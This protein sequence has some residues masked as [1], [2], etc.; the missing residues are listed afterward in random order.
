MKSLKWP[1]LGL[2]LLNVAVSLVFFLS[3]EGAYRDSIELGYAGMARFFAAHPSPFGWAPL[4]YSG[5]PSHLWYL[6]VI[7]YTGAA[8]MLLMP[9]TEPY[10]AYRLWVVTL[11]CL[12]PVTLFYFVY[13]FTGQRRWAGFT[14]ILFTLVS[15]SYAIF[16]ALNLDRGYNT[17][18][19]RLQLLVKY[20]EGP[21]N[22]GVMLAPLAL[23]ALWR[24]GQEWGFRRVFLA[25]A[26][27]AAVCLTN[28]VAA[29]SL[30]WCCLAMLAAWG[31]V[32]GERRTFAMRLLGTAGLAYLLASFWLTPRYV[33]TTVFNWPVDAIDF[34]PVSTQS[35]VT[36]LV[37]LAGTLMWMLRRRDGYLRFLALSFL[38]FLYV[39]GAHYWFG[40]DVI[41]EG[42]RYVLE[43]EWFGMVLAVELLRRLANSGR[44]WKR[45]LALLGCGAAAGLGAWQAGGFLALTWQKLHPFD[46]ENAPEW[47]VARKLNE[48]KPEG[49]VAVSGGT[50]FR[51]NAWFDVPQLGGTF[52]T[53]LR[54][55]TPVWALYQLRS[56]MDSPRERRVQDAEMLMK[57]A[58]VE[59]VA[60]HGPGSR[61]YYRDIKDAALFDARWEAVFREGEDVIY[62]VPFRGLSHLVRSEELPAERPI[63]P[64]VPL[65]E[66]YVRGLED[67]G[68]PRLSTQWR[69]PSEI[70]IRGEVPEKMLVSVLVSYDGGWR[71]EQDGR[72]LV[73]DR[74]AN[75]HIL[76]RPAAAAQ[77]AIRLRYRPTKEHVAM[78]GVSGLTWA[79]CL[80]LLWRRRGGA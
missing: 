4:Q 75:D 73:V 17:I 70:E 12:A 58:G 37:V 54:N 19:W 25:A 28:W 71:A 35:I 20:G 57:M 39:S 8:A 30:A 74:D 15:F 38:G 47:R 26:L 60:I 64:R 44:P 40:I 32:Q 34:K 46:R 66:A 59:Y 50:R 52:E 51:L 41:P 77:T 78:T 27:L 3:G 1:L 22:A 31:G 42:R 14:A 63:G 36:V 62:R 45:D 5:L 33:V 69:G 53:G 49:R 48:L 13:R 29:F 23:V 10:H 11:A 55:R 16:P 80:V 43:T 79:G 21:H 67:E 61:E 9:F 18:P 65:G 56:G 2:F 72:P 68:R 76:L 24:A 6:P 7:P